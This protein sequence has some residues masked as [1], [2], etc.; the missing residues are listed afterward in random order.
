[1]STNEAWALFG[2][3]TY[4]LNEHVVAHP[5]RPPELDHVRSLRRTLRSIPR[6]CATGVQLRDEQGVLLPDDACEREVDEDFDRPTWRAALNYSPTE[7]ML[8]YGSVAT[9]IARAASTGAPRTTSAL[10]PF[11]EETVHQL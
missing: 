1:M 8:I 3:G 11:E 2:E 6:P 9:A 7:D 5:G 10:Q 4:T